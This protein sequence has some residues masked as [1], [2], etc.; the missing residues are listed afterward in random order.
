MPRGRARTATLALTVVASLLAGA[1]PAAADPPA[2]TDYRSTV[3][4][5][6]PTTDGV[7]AQV[8]GGDAFLELRVDVGREVL[9]SGYGDE[10]YL[11][12]RPDGTVERNRRSEATYLN[13]DRQGG[14]ELPAD[15]DN[16]ADP[17]WETVA[18]G[19]T[20]AWHDHRIHWMGASRPPGA[21]PGDLVQEWAVPMTVDGTAVEVRGELVL[22][23]PTSPLPWFALAVGGLAAVVAL[24]RRR[25]QPTAGLAVLVAAT[26]A[27][28][29][30]WAEWSAAPAGAGADPLLVAVP[31]VGV[32]AALAG[33]ALRGRPAAATATLAAA[34][35][36][37]GWAVLRADVLWT[38]VLPTDVPF[39]LDR[40]VTAL[41]LGLPAGAAALVV[42]A[43]G[44]AGTPTPARAEREPGDSER[45]A[46]RR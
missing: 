4:A 27:L 23:E 9:V 15:A 29:I 12:F 40:A 19:G 34:A 30:G 18:S 36:T 35:A 38:P 37:L 5:V 31:L 13:E 43:G 11:R 25:P 16:E 22:A 41:A 33:V 44:L 3:T 6:D 17:E 24:G 42:W 1:R 32:V 2:P 26:A 46:D 45:G 8:V 39:A 14:V 7:E 10:P 28:G 20:Y 21:E